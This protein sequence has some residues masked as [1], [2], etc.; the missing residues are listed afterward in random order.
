M[1]VNIG[2][3]MNNNNYYWYDPSSFFCQYCGCRFQMY[4][5]PQPRMMMMMPQPVQQPSPPEEKDGGILTLS[6]NKLYTDL[7]VDIIE[8]NKPKN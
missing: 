5:Q 1:R 6:D 3:I 8:K 4:P 7:I 2:A